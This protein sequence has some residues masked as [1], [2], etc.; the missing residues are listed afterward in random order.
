M[1]ETANV[2]EL[3]HASITWQGN[4]VATVAIRN[5]GPLNV[6]SAAVMEDVRS[7][8]THVSSDPRLRVLVVRGQG[9]DAFVA[10]ADV[11]EMVDLD[12]PGATAFITRLYALCES[13]RNCPVPVIAARLTR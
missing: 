8:I 1:T 4:E 5:A 3:G 7:A 10:G 9:D 13:V 6:L 12:G 2:P 11:R